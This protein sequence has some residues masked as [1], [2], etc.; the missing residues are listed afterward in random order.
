M[1]GHV[2]VHSPMPPGE[3]T[4]GQVPNPG[5]DPVPD[6]PVD[7]VPDRPIDPTP[8]RP[9]DPDPGR[10]ID[11]D[12]GRPNEPVQLPGDPAGP[13]VGEPGTQAKRMIS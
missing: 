2:S 10:P 3:D 9:I 12:P 13:G 4:P 6:Q 8:D 1:A 5:R 11:P 7:P